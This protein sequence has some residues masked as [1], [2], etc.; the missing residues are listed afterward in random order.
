MQRHTLSDSSKVQPEVPAEIKHRHRITFHSRL[1]QLQSLQHQDETKPQSISLKRKEI[2]PP[3]TPDAPRKKLV[4]SQ[5]SASYRATTAQLSQ[6]EKR[7]KY[8][9][10]WVKQ[11]MEEQ[12]Q[13]IT[14]LQQQLLSQQ[15]KMNTLLEEAK[16]RNKDVLK[17]TLFEKIAKS[18]EF[19]QCMNGAELPSTFSNSVSASQEYDQ[20][21]LLEKINTYLVSVGKP[22]T[23][24]IGHCHGITLLWLAMMYLGLESLFYSMAKTIAECPDKQLHKIDKTITTFLEWI[25]LG[26]NPTR[27][28]N[29]QYGQRDVAKI[30]G[31]V[32]EF[33]A[34]KK[35]IS[36]DQL[37][38][39]L[40]RVAQVNHMICFAGKGISKTTQLRSGH[41]IGVFIKRSKTNSLQYCVYDPNYTT[42]KHKIFDTPETAAVECWNR[43]FANLVLS[44]IRSIEMDVVRPPSM[45]Q[46]AEFS[47]AMG[48]AATST[49]TPGSCRASLF[50]RSA[51]ADAAMPQRDPVRSNTLG[52]RHP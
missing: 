8:H 34:V 38:H 1:G 9:E 23:T 25:D 44:K 39:E 35:D 12:Q 28:S 50:A 20:S 26:Q 31:G 18:E 32:T 5:S 36:Q 46:R 41:A 29:N 30:I 3:T 13:Y 40:K 22:E 21:V 48:G 37:A 15:L 27:Y 45:T 14:Q 24:T 47:K 7:K 17:E 19:K 33:A 10:A 43:A 4:V 49:T 2:S 16:Q 52:M 6:P 51:Q 42:N 11:K